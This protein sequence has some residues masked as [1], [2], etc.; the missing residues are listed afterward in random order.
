MA[1]VITQ[2]ERT[3]EHGKRSGI[4]IERLSEH[5]GAAVT[6]VDLSRQ[7]SADEF[8]DVHDA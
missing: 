8:A 1:T 4:R 7:I 6:G 5:T 3:V 2:M